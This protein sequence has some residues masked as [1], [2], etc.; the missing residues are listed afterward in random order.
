M[1]C[2]REVPAVAALQHEFNDQGLVLIAIDLDDD[3]AA[4]EAFRDKYGTSFPVAVE[5]DDRMRKAFGVRGC[6]ATVIIDRK[7]RMVGRAGGGDGDWTSDAARALARSLLGA[8]MA[9]GPAP[10]RKRQARKS[11]HL[12]TAVA[13]NDTKLNEILDEAAAALKAGDEVKILFDAQSV[14][15]LRMN[16]QKTPLQDAPFTDA[17]RRAAARRL[18]VPQSAAPRNQLDYIQLL[19]KAGAKVLVN[20]NAVHAFGLADDEIHPI[21]KRV[22]VEDME[23]IVDDSDACLNY[24][25]E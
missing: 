4:L 23:R 17:Q 2:Q 1:P 24:S 14:G 20:E 8:R 6:P 3:R 7:G 22:S 25:R 18:G 13:P 21:A 10:A 19:A 16:A 9:S 12:M 15:A 5:N 11:V